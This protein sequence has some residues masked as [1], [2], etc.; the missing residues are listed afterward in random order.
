MGLFRDIINVLIITMKSS[1]G[2]DVLTI[3]K[4]IGNS[5]LVSNS[6]IITYRHL[7]AIIKVNLLGLN[8]PRNFISVIDGEL[9]RYGIDC[10]MQVHFSLSKFDYN[11]KARKEI[12]VNISGWERISKNE[13]GKSKRD[14]EWGLRSAKTLLA[15]TSF[16]TSM[17]I[18]LSAK[19]GMTLR[20]AVNI[21]K[22]CI[23]KSESL[24]F[25]ATF[26]LNQRMQEM[27]IT[28]LAPNSG[29]SFPALANTIALVGPE[30]LV[31]SKHGTVIGKNIYTNEPYAIDFSK[32]TLARNMLIIAPSGSGKT[33]MMYN[34]AQ[35]T[36][37]NGMRMSVVDIKGNEYVTLCKSVDGAVIDLSDSSTSYIDCVK[38]IPFDGDYRTYFNNMDILLKDILC[39]L[40][41]EY[42]S[43]K[44]EGL[45]LNFITALW[46]NKGVS[47]DNPDTWVN[48]LTMDIFT[49]FEDFVRYCYRQSGTDKDV[50]AALDNM[51]KYVTRTGEYSY[52]WQNPL[53][54]ND[55][56]S[57]RMIS[58]SF[59]ILNG[60][61]TNQVLFKLRWKFMDTIMSDY[62]YN[63]YKTG[64][65]TLNIMEE[66]QI[67]D[68]DIMKM[69]CRHWT[70]GRSLKQDNIFI[71]NSFETIKERDDAQPI[72]ENAT[73]IITSSMPPKTRESFIK[74]YGLDDYVHMLNDLEKP[75]NKFSFFIYLRSK[76]LP[77]SVIVSISDGRELTISKP[78]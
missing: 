31:K 71:A 68:S 36:L 17:S 66:A 53:N 14:A 59:G 7:S 28:S 63:N 4:N 48:T 37:E 29:Q 69:Y 35:N 40:A 45:V 73:I 41:G 24:A 12:T 49:V 62:F 56:L 72:L 60:K 32:E 52:I 9:R 61:I 26:S 20:K 55:I 75:D 15:D 64:Y 1:L 30:P 10:L 21:V 50:I 16:T 38:R 27:C 54:I 11:E 18:K 78:V 58:Y 42:N 57:K 77:P 74:T 47:A 44:L 43:E 22:Q 3:P 70:L 25:S 67:V 5:L 65:I 39:I 76:S 8:V 23:S 19:D 13:Q 34:I 2:P 33:Y 46:I 6:T 51:N